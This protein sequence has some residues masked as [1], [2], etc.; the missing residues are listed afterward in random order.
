LQQDFDIDL[1]RLYDQYENGE[2]TE[3]VEEPVSDD[4]LFADSGLHAI[5]LPKLTTPSLENLFYAF[6][7]ETRPE[8]LPKTSM[9]MKKIARE[10]KR[11]DRPLSLAVLQQ[12]DLQDEQ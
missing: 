5:H 6:S 4:D 3:S 12:Y 2:L 9:M 8:Y 7:F 1:S 11:R 10:F